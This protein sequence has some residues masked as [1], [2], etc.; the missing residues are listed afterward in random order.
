MRIGLLLFKIRKGDSKKKKKRISLNFLFWIDEVFKA[1]IYEL[2]YIFLWTELF[3][4]CLLLIWRN[5]QAFDFFPSEL[6]ILD[7]SN[8]LNKPADTEWAFST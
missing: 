2:K 3:L 1:Y 4:N 6:K 7:K 5:N 8:P